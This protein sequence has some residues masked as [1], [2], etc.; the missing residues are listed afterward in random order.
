MVAN[1]TPNQQNNGLP[2]AMERLSMG[3]IALRILN[4]S[5]I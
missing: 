4:K 1:I 3:I 2:D 5:L